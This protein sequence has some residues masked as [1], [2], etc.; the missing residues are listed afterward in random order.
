M[1]PKESI[2]LY[3]STEVQI[4][5]RTNM[6]KL[7][8]FALPIASIFVSA[9]KNKPDMIMTLSQEIAPAFGADHLNTKMDVN[10][11]NNGVVARIT[12]IK[13]SSGP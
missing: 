1:P 2:T 13:F 6:L 8:P 12:L 7:R 11:T 5:E 9:P 3:R 4:I 10:R